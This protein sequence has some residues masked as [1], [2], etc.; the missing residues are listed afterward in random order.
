MTWNHGKLSENHFHQKNVL[1][2]G[3]WLLWLLWSIYY[4]WSTNHCV[5]YK[6]AP[7][8]FKTLLDIYELQMFHCILQNFP[9]TLKYLNFIKIQKKS[10]NVT[11]ITNAVSMDGTLQFPVNKTP[12]TKST[13]TVM[14]KDA[15]HKNN[16]NYWA[17][18]DSRMLQ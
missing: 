14:L 18:R 17:C 1:H 13:K 8:L 2:I 10:Y 15:K 7:P 16:F 3:L 5:G 9:F 6:F 4:D 11:W 12:R